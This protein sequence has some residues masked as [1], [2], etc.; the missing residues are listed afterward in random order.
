[1]T[2]TPKVDYSKL[3][4]FR[5]AL[6]R[7]E[8]WSEEQARSAGLTPAQHQLLLCIRGSRD[9]TDPTISDIAE[10]LM[11]RHHSTVE[12]I[13]RAESSG[14]V[15]RRSDPVDARMIRVGLTSAG[16]R[17]LDELTEAHI[18]ELRRLEALLRP[19]VSV[20]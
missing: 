3:L 10:A 20:D 12:L 2:R 5:V 4:G 7:F 1:M 18:E 11:L 9:Q 17:V 6:R 16:D 14:L 8:R 15:S 13:D 19:A